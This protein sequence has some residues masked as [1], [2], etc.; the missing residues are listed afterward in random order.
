M[1]KHEGGIGME[2]MEVRE[3]QDLKEVAILGM[4]N[5]PVGMFGRD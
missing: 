2:T 3:V 4:T 1:N 5:F